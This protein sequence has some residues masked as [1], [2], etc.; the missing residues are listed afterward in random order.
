MGS[1]PPP[2]ADLH[3]ITLP[4]RYTI[5]P[6]D[7]SVA[8]WA[9]ALQIEGFMMRE[10]SIW[11]PLVPAPRA[12][13]TLGALEALDGHFAH[14]LA[15]GMSYGIFDE[16]YTPRRGEPG[17]YWHELDPGEEDFEHRGPEAMRDAMDFPLVCAALSV[18]ACDPKPA[19]ASEALYECIPLVR[20]LGRFLAGLRAGGA[21]AGG[22]PCPGGSG[23]PWAPARRGELLV[24]SGCVTRRGYEA[25][26]LMGA[27]NR[28]VLLEARARGF[29]AVAAGVANPSVYRSWA[30][31]P[32]GC[33]TRV[34]ARFDVWAIEL[35][36][37]DNPGRRVRPYV[38]SAVSREG[39]LL[40][41]DVNL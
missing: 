22:G 29:R 36:D 16:E 15:G 32:P 3:G 40:W 26:G 25:R 28:F 11:A 30:R 4:P 21:G 6:L 9:K 38:G 31:A 19:A 5:R 41:C 10:S 18:D 8:A 20:P 35:E 1:L 2:V 33:R 37:P 39:W 12:A 24:R 34:V 13:R 23:E 7:T 14:A 17:V 27:L